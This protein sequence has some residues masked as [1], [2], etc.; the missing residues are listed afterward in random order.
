[1]KL[2]FLL[3]HVNKAP[4]LLVIKGIK[5]VT[6]IPSSQPF[7]EPGI[8]PGSRPEEAGGSGGTLLEQTTKLLHL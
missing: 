3:V 8:P 2:H 5:T 1:M 6:T 4:H 7:Q